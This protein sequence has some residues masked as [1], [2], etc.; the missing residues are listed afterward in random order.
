MLERIYTPMF[1][2]SIFRKINAVDKKKSSELKDVN[3][4]GCSKNV[5]CEVSH[6]THSWSNQYWLPKFQDRSF[7]IST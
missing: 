4:N 7:L 2:S 5:S 6:K 1:M 3:S